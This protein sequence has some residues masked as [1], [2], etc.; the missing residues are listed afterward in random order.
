MITLLSLASHGR[1]LGHYNLLDL[2]SLYSSNLYNNAITVFGGYTKE[3][4]GTKYK[5]SLHVS[6]ENGSLG[7]L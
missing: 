5:P 3:D 7:Q 2:Q 4:N 6:S 1:K